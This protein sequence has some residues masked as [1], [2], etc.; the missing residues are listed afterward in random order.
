[1]AIKIITERELKQC[2]HLD[3]EAIEV[4]REAFTALASGRVV[5]PPILPAAAIF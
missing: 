1:M 5:M 3:L 2:V 4:V